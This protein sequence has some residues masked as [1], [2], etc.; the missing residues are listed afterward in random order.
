MIIYVTKETFDQYEFKMPQDF[1]DQFVGAM[2]GAVLERESGDPLLEWGGK[3][4]YF[5]NMQCLQVVNFAS[6]LTLVL[7]DIKTEDKE[8]IPEYIAHYLFNLYE[9]NNKMKKLLERFF[10]DY[11]TAC[12]SRLIDKSIIS[13]LN[14]FQS[15]FLLDG[16]RLADYISDGILHSID[17]NKYI[18]CEYLLRQKIN[19]KMEYIYPAE[20]FQQLLCERYGVTEK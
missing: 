15:N 16:Y 4:F 19:G 17:L 14:S 7:I 10:K 18:N 13:S 8:N 5:N 12:F 9:N 6:K 11:P 2:A 3:L 20:R 1:S